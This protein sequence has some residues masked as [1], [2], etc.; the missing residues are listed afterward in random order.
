MK[1]GSAN[2]KPREK[3]NPDDVALCNFASQLQP[4]RASIAVGRVRLRAR[5]PL[6]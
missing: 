4:M 5:S 6:M 1:R 2:R 3:E